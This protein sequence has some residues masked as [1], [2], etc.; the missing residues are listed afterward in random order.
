MQLEH[1]SI[2]PMTIKTKVSVLM[3]VYS[4][5]FSLAKK[6]I[7]SVLN[8]DMQNFELIIIDDGTI[9]IG[10][11]Q[12]ANYAQKHEHK[13]T[14]IR[15]SNR[16]Q[17]ASIN[18]GVLNSIG[19]FIAIIDADD[20][21]KPNHLRSCLNEMY[22]ADL[23]ASTTETIVDKEDDYYVPDLY[24]NKKLIHVDDCILFATLFGRKEVFTKIKFQGNYAAD[25]DFY[26]R[27]SQQFRVKKTDL[28]TYIYYRNNPNSTCEIIKQQ[29]LALSSNVFPN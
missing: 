20:E 29:N 10:A 3:S 22:T 5:E 4:T 23:I 7:D 13:I 26:Y 17:V 14:Y 6:A 19:E 16:G 9:H 12:L 21:Y 15:H 8:Q 27:A 1:E 18:V 25:A 11:N 2:L 24:N 28:R